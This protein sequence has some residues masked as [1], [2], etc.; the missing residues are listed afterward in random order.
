VRSFLRRPR[1]ARALVLG[2]V[3]LLGAVTA[4]GVTAVP[5][6]AMSVESSTPAAGSQ[7]AEPPG[8][9]QIE[10]D[11]I[12]FFTDFDI[13]VTGPDG[14]ATNGI[15]IVIGR[16]ATQGLDDDLPNGRY[17][18]TWAVGESLL[19]E[20]GRGSFTFRVGPPP[21][22]ELPS[23]S[24]EASAPPARDLPAAG[25]TTAPERTP[26]A[27]PTRLSPPVSAT[28]KAP[29]GVPAAQA[30]PT[31]N[32]PQPD[33][34]GVSTTSAEWLP[35][36]AFWWGLLAVVV[37]AL[38]WRRRR[39]NRPVEVEATPEPLLRQTELVLGSGPGLTENDGPSP[40]SLTP[41]MGVPRL[42]VVLAP[43]APGDDAERQVPA[44]ADATFIH[45]RDEARHRQHAPS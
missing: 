10:F 39:R 9:I 18:V 13:S 35:P 21:A 38:T 30:R 26:K 34:A 23:A 20:G 43:A 33:V 12:V 19:D 36:P 45:T 3:A 41:T 5:A 2:A 25:A 44:G 16:I 24:A 14:D 11:D 7:N 42:S 27:E 8:Q 31:Q 4:V 15:P 40:Q 22:R 28:A 1:P 32:V 17:T 29:G 37:G 6:A